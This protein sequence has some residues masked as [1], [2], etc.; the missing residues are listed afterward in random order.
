ME[1]PRYP[2]GQNK[3]KYGW[4]LKQCIYIFDIEKLWWPQTDRDSNLMSLRFDRQR[5]RT[6]LKV[7]HSIEHW[8]ATVLRVSHS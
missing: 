8:S 5:T 6:I 7:E 1:K 2:N 3:Q 4:A